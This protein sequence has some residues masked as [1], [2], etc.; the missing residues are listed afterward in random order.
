VR[1]DLQTGSIQSLADAPRSEDAGLWAGVFSGPRWSSDGQAIL[2]PGTF[3]K[4]KENVPSRPCVAV[5]DLLSN[6]RTCVEIL[7]GRTESSAEEGFHHIQEARFAGGDKQRIIVRFRSHEDLYS[8]GTIEYQ[9]TAAGTWQVVGHSKSVPEIGHDGLE[10]SVKQGLNEPPL[11]VATYKQS[12]HVIWDPNPQLKNIELGQAEVYKWKD[13]DGREWRGGLF[14]PSHYQPGQRYPLVIQGHG[15]TEAKF[16]PS[17]I[18]PTAFAAR[19]LAATGIVV[20]QLSEGCPAVTLA[21]GRCVVSGYEAAANKLVSEGLVDPEK[22]GMIGFSR[23]CFYVMETLT[24]GSLHLRAASITE[25]LMADYLQYLLGPD[26]V[27]D[28]YNAMIGATPFGEGLRTWLARSPG[29]NLDKI[30]TPLMVV[31]EG[32]LSVLH[33]WEPYAVLRYLHKPVDLIMLN[34]DEHVLT[35]PTVRLA[36]QGGSV[37]WFRFWLQGYEDPDSAK[38]GQYVRWRELRKLQEEIDKKK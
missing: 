34:T 37:D 8:F 17:G 36:S 29:F 32:P 24:T 16:I 25:G 21:E 6:T 14:K 28:E 9:H 33:M 38:A 35:N 11:V 4:S 7:K 19:E 31:G 5:A 1:I 30:N 3:L 22:I 20:L 26:W 13:K 12:S 2:L 23:T 18:F 27:G 10:V 15:F